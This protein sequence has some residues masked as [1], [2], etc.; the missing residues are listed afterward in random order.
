M[1]QSVEFYKQYIGQKITT[2]PSAFGN[3]LAG[4]ILQVE[5]DS[6]TIEFEVREN[7][8]NPVKMLHGGM[9]AA[10]MDEVLGMTI[11]VNGI[12]DFFFS[13]NLNVNFIANV[14]VGTNVVVT[15]KLIKKSQKL[16]QAECYAYGPGGKLLAKG[17]SNL[18]SVE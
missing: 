10:M 18:I 4:K 15:A 16:I 6:L 5:E 12:K 11:F 1:N 13:V 2:A 14:N 9:M 17:S 7:M 8:T 3:W